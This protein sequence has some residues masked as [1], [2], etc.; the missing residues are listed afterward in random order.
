MSPGIPALPANV[1]TWPVLMLI[2]RIVWLLHS[3][4]NRLFPSTVISVDLLNS[5]KEPIPSLLP[6]TPGVPA[7]VVT[8]PEEILIY[9]LYDY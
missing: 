3:E 7:I 8:D 6:E 1:V 9:G 2:F 5:A 4:T